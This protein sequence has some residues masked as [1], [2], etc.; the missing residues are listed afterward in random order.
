MGT[1][2]GKNL[3]ILR[4]RVAPNG[5]CAVRKNPPGTE[6]IAAQSASAKPSTEIYRVHRLGWQLDFETPRTEA[7]NRSRNPRGFFL[8]P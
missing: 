1:F 6:N 2:T 5:A 3:R 8:K 4:L 7:G